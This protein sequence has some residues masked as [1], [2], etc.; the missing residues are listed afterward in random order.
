VVLV[1]SKKVNELL[2]T[3]E[4]LVAQGCAG[5]DG[6][7]LNSGF[8]STYADA[9]RL[10]ER[11]GRMKLIKNSGRLVIGMYVKNGKTSATTN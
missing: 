4:E 7:T 10:L 8:I 5:H 2:D 6:D 1:A 9:M 11:H 3:I